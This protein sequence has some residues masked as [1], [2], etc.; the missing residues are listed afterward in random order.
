MK[1]ALLL[2]CETLV[3]KIE[4]SE[5]LFV[6]YNHVINLPELFRITWVKTSL[7]V[8]HLSHL[9]I[10]GIGVGELSRLQIDIYRV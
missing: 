4:A 10:E 7:E 6:I 9:L 1:S 8:E 5:Y 3:L 2:H